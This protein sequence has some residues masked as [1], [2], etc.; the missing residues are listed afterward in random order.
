MY[1]RKLA[2]DLLLRCWYKKDI[3]AKKE[4]SPL[5]ILELYNGCISFYQQLSRKLMERSPLQ[6]ALVRHLYM[7]AMADIALQQ[8]KKFSLEVTKDLHEVFSG[9]SPYDQGLDEFFLKHIGEKPHFAELWSNVRYYDLVTRT[10]LC[11]KR[12]FR[13]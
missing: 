8:Q 3:E 5:Q 7:A 1:P 10:I 13:E 9:Y 2:L 11:R 6:H 12:V 4:A